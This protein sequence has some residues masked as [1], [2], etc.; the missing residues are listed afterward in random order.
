M[1]LVRPGSPTMSSKF[2]FSNVKN[3]VR[4]NLILI[5]DTEKKISLHLSKVVLSAITLINM[6]CLWVPTPYHSHK[7]RK[8]S[9]EVS[10]DQVLF[11]AEL[12]FPRMLVPRWPQHTSIKNTECAGKSEWSKRQYSLNVNS[13]LEHWY[14][15][16]LLFWY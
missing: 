3:S 13:F 6:Q 10:L 14:N 9:L 7:K 5:M 12:E 11:A 8:D 4:Y 2:Y 1:S 15:L 16:I